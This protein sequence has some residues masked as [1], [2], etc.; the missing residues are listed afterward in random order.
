MNE[1]QNHNLYTPNPG[2][3]LTKKDFQT[4]EWGRESNASWAIGKSSNPV[5]FTADGH[6]VK[7]EDYAK[8]SS[9]LI[10]HKSSIPQIN[11]SGVH[12][13]GIDE[14][15]NDIKVNIWSVF[16]V[17]IGYNIKPWLNPTILK[18]LPLQYARDVRQDKKLTSHSPNCFYYRRHT[19]FNAANYLLEETIWNDN[20]DFSE[21]LSTL[22]L[23]IVLGYR[24]IFIS[25]NII[26]ENN[27]T[28][29]HLLQIAP[30]L[31]NFNI[32]MSFTEN[33]GSLPKTDINKACEQCIL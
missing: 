11:L 4:V 29:K 27:K 23:A 12:V 2:S 33:I 9:V 16:G 25:A 32:S 26:D 19:S 15:A 1:I 14:V 31:S 28:F 17:P 8:G 6:N 3:S 30:M 21:I 22:K 24:K 5:F 18:L 7:L 20:S 10:V 13:W